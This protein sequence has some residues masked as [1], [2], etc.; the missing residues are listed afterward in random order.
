MPNYVK[1][2]KDILSKKKRLGEY[3]TVELTKE[4]N[5]FL[6]NKLPLKMK[7]PGI[8]TIPCEVRPTTMTLKLAD[9]SLAYPKGKVE[10]VLAMKF[11]NSTEEC[12]VM[13]ELEILVSMEWENNFVEDPLEKTL[14]FEPL[15]DEQDNIIKKCIARSEIDEIFYHCQSSPNG[16]HFGGS[17]TAMKILQVGFFWPTVFKDAYIVVSVYYVSKWVEVEAYL[18]NDA[19]L[20]D[21]YNVK[22]KI[23]A[24]YHPQSNGQVE[25]VNHD[26]RGILEKVVQ[27]NRKDWS[28][29]L[30]DGI[31]AYRTT[32]KRPLG[33]DP[34]WS[35]FGKVCHLPLELE[36]KAY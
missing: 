17:C 30:D 1:F 24:A 36:N 20:L 21:K 26:I 11:P 32:F 35:V 15:E 25:W 4:C 14:G 27:P 9:G 23:V 31:W 2:M 6:Q 18:T 7:D 34:Y 3:E 10:D 13:E 5:A 28:Q 22:H 12:S 29:R 19:K 33:T 16:G 8:F